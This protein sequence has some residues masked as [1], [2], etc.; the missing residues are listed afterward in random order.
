MARMD[1]DGLTGGQSILDQFARQRD[2]GGAAAGH[3]LEDEPVAAEEPGPEGLLKGDGQLDPVGPGQKAVLVD[4]V[5]PSGLEFHRLDLPGHLGG[6]GDGAG[7]TLAEYWVMK[8]EPPPA[9]RLTTPITPLDPAPLVAVDMV[10]ALVIQLSSPDS[11]TI[12]C[13]GCRSISSTGMTV[14]MTRWA[15]P[16]AASAAAALSTEACVGP[17]LPRVTLQADTTSRRW[18]TT[19]PV[20]V[21]RRS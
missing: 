12:D 17:T 8:S 9:T 7:R 21:T 20:L 4:P 19:S 11:E 10:M 18:P 3:L 13:P 16:A 2:P 14:P 6:E 15:T 5:V 1:P